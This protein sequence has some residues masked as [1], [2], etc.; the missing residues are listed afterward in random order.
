MPVLLSTLHDAHAENDDK[1]CRYVA[2]I[3][4]ALTAL[5][6]VQL[7]IATR[8]AVVEVVR[9]SRSRDSDTQR[10]AA[11]AIGQERGQK[12]RGAAIGDAR[13]GGGVRGGV[14]GVRETRGVDDGRGRASRDDDDDDDERVG[15][16]TGE[17][18]RAIGRPARRTRARARTRR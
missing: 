9:L 10:H 3:L 16:R 8:Q 1:S 2:C 18:T 12:R 6:E 5:P 17:W 13:R 14:R 4:G 15:V 7:E 11:R